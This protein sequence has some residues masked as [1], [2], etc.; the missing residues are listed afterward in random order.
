MFFGRKAKIRKA[1]DGV[2]A[3]IGD[4]G[5]APDFAP[6]EALASDLHV[7]AYYTLTLALYED[8]L[9]AQAKASLERALALAPDERELHALAAQIDAELGEVDDAIEA[10]RRVVAKNPKDKT[11]LASLAELLIAAERIDEAIEV[12]Q[13]DRDDP[14][15]DTRLAEALFLA[16]RNEEAL[17]LLDEACALYDAQ[18]KQLS[19]ADWQAL[20]SRADEADRL[21]QDVYAELHGR[22]ATIELAAAAGK[23]DAQA[24]VNFR[25]LGAR[26]A[27]KSDRIA[28]VLELQTP[29]ATEARGETLLRANPK[30][31]SGLVLVGS[32]QLRRGDLE[33]ARKTFERA[34]EA[35]GKNFA[36]FLGLGAVMDHEQHRLHK[37]VASLPRS[38]PPPELALVVPD[39]PALTDLEQHVVWAS[40]RPLARMLPTLAERDVKMR[41]LPIDVRA[42]DIDLFKD[43]A[44][45]RAEDDH[46]SYDAITGIAT[47][48]GA[49]AKIEELLDIVTDGGWTFAH[50]LAHLAFFHIPEA[51]AEPLLEIYERA[52]QVGYA[53]IE[54]AL[55]N[56]DEFF[57]VSY[58]DYLR[59]RYEL[60]DVPEADD[61]GIQRDLMKYFDQLSS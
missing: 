4:E 6:I 60:P 23:L 61:A 7:Q 44:G 2:L 54:Y 15:L 52:L 57:A 16:N 8:E 5:A 51:Q 29:D 35:D 38:I 46:R 18:L 48:G 58:A 19:G 37:R 14:V 21:R 47:H 27:A 13:G 34:C 40:I 33:D 31:A 17:E 41:I 20:K 30:S 53:N 1:V 43:A 36:A 39:L 59:F 55:Q 28:D 10:Q 50:E 22:E 49:V 24:G 3:S 11:A 12:L 32:A 26:L 25:L 45:E 9:Y 56:A 42:T